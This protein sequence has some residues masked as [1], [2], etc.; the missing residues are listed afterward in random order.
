MCVC[1]CVCVGALQYTMLIFGF[2]SLH[3]LRQYEG[4][5]HV[6]LYD[7]LLQLYISIITIP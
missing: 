1:V 7:T 4:E 2:S 6:T 3:T 5:N